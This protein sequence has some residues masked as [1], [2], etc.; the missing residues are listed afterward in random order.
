MAYVVVVFCIINGF[1]LVWG[2]L[3]LAGFL[4]D[5]PAIVET[6]IQDEVRKQDERIEKRAQ[7]AKGQDQ[8][9]D[10]TDVAN[11]SVRLEAGRPLRR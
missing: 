9:M 5:M 8:D 11:N 6:A 3:L 2:A 4:K 10:G 1:A 7:R